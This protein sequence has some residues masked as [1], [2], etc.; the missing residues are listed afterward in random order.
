[1]TFFFVTPNPLIFFQR[2]VCT[3]FISHMPVPPVFSIHFYF[4]IHFT[5]RSIYQKCISKLLPLKDSVHICCGSSFKRW[6][7]F[8]F[9]LF[10]YFLQF[11]S[12]YVLTF[13]TSSNIIYEYVYIRTSAL[14]KQYFKQDLPSIDS[15][16]Q[17]CKAWEVYRFG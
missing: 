3:H 1:M 14:M 9:P 12:N 4:F 17:I 16:I 10:S 5:K 6:K 13:H 8:L 11:F 15:A 7:T 2:K